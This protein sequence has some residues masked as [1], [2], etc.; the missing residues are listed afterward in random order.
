MIN[1]QNWIEIKIYLKHMKLAR[2]CQDKSLSK[3]WTC[4]RHLLE[5]AGDRPLPTVR[6]LDPSF[7]TYLT[8]APRVDGKAIPLASA[9]I[10]KTM[11]ITRQFFMF[12]RSEWPRRYRHLSENWIEL[13]QPTR[14]SRGSAQLVEHEFYSLADVRRLLSVSA[15]T[16]KEER[17]QAAAAMLFLSGMRPDT[18][19]SMPVECVNIADREI[20]QV[21]LM[22]VR[23]K[24][25]KAARTYLLD[26]PDLLEVVAA[27]DA[28]ARFAGNKLWFAGIG[29]DGDHFKPLTHAVQGRASV[30]S[31]DLARLCAQA[32]VEYHSPH[33]FRHGHIVYARSMVRTMDELKAVSQNVMHASVVT[34]DQIYGALMNNSVRDIILG[35]GSQQ[36]PSRDDIK[37]MLEQILAK[38]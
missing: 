22:G 12:A 14:A 17:V 21:P 35:L 4:L 7:S 34:T 24:N 28:R 36:D 11:Q 6:K 29:R 38:I 23:T 32:E 2:Q 37:K 5:W 33:K 8:T 1:R 25:D 13:L 26:I 16:L 27:W 19:A 20:M 15:A 3:A 18:L 9:T 31:K 10:I 30:I